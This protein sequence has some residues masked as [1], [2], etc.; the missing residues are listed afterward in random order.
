MIGSI[1][2]YSIGAFILICG[3]LIPKDH[4][5]KYFKKADQS[6]SSTGSIIG[7]ILSSIIVFLL[8]FLPWY[9]MKILLL[10]LGLTLI[11]LVY[12]Y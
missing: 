6:I 9:V 2:A 3:I 12:L 1:I 7:D 11:I 5:D 10:L 8:G 4:Y